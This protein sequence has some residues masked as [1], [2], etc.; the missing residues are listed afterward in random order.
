MPSKCKHDNSGVKGYHGETAH[1]KFIFLA[2]AANVVQ[3]PLYAIVHRSH[4][5]SSLLA[6]KQHAAQ[7]KKT[8]I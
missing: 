4:P 6:Q 5:F 3:K 8:A 1:A 2:P 7:H